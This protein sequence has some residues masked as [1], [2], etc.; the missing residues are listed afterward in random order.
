MDPSTWLTLATWMIV[1]GCKILHFIDV[2][3]QEALGYKILRRKKEV[4]L[5]KVYEF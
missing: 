3:D 5:H 4:A 2:K 1:V